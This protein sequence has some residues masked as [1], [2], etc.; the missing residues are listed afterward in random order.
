[1]PRW[2]TIRSYFVPPATRG[3][4]DR[5]TDRPEHEARQEHRDAQPAQV[6]VASSGEAPFMPLPRSAMLPGMDLPATMAAL[7]KLGNAQMRKTWATHGATGEFFGVKIGDMKGLVKRIKG[8]HELAIELYATGN[9]D[10]MYLAGL[11]A[12]PARMSI[13]D[14]DTWVE[15]A[16]W[17]M[18]SEYTVPWVAAESPHGRHVALR[19]IDAKNPRIAAAGWNTYAGIV[20]LRADAELDLLEIDGLL[21]RVERDIGKAQDRVRYCMNGFVIAVGAAVK[22]LLGKAKATARSLG[23]VDVDMGGTSC[24]VP[25][26][27]MTIEKIEAMGRVGKKRETMRC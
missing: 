5:A 16:R 8:R 9:L 2:S 13:R 26:A 23:K 24:K 22:P 20:A 3:A 21:R 18:I 15:A 10:A 6:W 4:R 12:D 25:P 19:W 7:E 14:L 11:V 27:L 17:K 1:M